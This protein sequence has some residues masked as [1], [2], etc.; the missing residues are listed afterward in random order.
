M[1]TNLM[2]KMPTKYARTTSRCDDDD[3]G[4]TTKIYL[5]IGR[6]LWG[7]PRGVGNVIYIIAMEVNLIVQL[8]VNFTVA[9]ARA[10][11]ALKTRQK[12]TFITF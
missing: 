8:G 7:V 12:A 3:E 6:W 1:R 5:R 9:R 11:G 2:R 10:C 4:R